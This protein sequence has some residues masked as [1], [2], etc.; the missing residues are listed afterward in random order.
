MGVQIEE[1]H[2]VILVVGDYRASSVQGDRYSRGVRWNVESQPG[3]VAQRNR[4]HGLRPPFPLS[5]VEMHAIVAAAADDKCRPI[6]SPCQPIMCIG[7]LNH[8]PLNG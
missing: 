5:L 1:A 8:L 3:T 2:R 4:W 7:N 6:R